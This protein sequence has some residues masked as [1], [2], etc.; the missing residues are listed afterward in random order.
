MSV[1]DTS[2]VMRVISTNLRNHTNPLAENGED[3]PRSDDVYP[4]NVK[5]V[6]VKWDSTRNLETQA[7]LV[8]TSTF[9]TIP[10]SFVE[11]Y[12]VVYEDNIEFEEF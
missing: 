5:R 1:I 11:L 4:S 10:R 12:D 7:H 2:G 6:V 9:T 8:K 3:L